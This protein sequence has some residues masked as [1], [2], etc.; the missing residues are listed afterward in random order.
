MMKTY[1]IK[2]RHRKPNLDTLLTRLSK[3][4]RSYADWQKEYYAP[5]YDVKSTIKMDIDLMHYDYLERLKRK[6]KEKSDMI[7]VFKQYGY[8]AVKGSDER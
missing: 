7:A 6:S 3:E 8:N 4:G 1:V 5:Y 2:Y